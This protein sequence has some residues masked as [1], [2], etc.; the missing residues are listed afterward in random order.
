MN[1]SGSHEFLVQEKSIPIPNEAPKKPS[2]V[3]D[4]VVMVDPANFELN[5]QTTDNALQNCTAEGILE[6]TQNKNLIKSQAKKE[7]HKVNDM[8]K[9]KKIQ[10]ITFNDSMIPEKP[11]AIFPNNPMSTHQD[12]SIILYSMKA[13]NR[14]LEVAQDRELIKTLLQQYNFDIRRVIDYSHMRLEDKHLEG[15]GSMVLDRANKVVYA[16][17]SQRTNQALLEQWG[18]DQGYEVVYFHAESLDKE[19]NIKPVYHTNVVMSVGEQY[20]VVCFDVIPDSNE[21]AKLQQKL[22]DTGKKIITISKEQYDQCAGNILELK[23]IQDEHFL[24]MSE[25]AY[26]SYKKEQL[27]IIEELGLQTLAIPI[28]TI[29]RIGGG[30]LRCMLLEIFLNKRKEKSVQVEK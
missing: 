17:I 2:Q 11:D 22:K 9:E 21:R 1:L 16:C 20:A 25:S 6:A 14:A 7:F 23:N 27:K 28:P 8:L 3:T 15:T 24:A 26:K 4:T 19:G 5:M 10:V 29:E 12:G 30:S 13:D 18:K